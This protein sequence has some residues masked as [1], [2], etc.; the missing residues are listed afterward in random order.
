M[1]LTAKPYIC[2]FCRNY[3]EMQVICR[4]QYSRV[5]TQGTEGLDECSTHR[6][7]ILACPLCDNINVWEIS[8][9]TIEEEMIGEEPDG[10]PIFYA[11]DRLQLVYPQVDVSI[12]SPNADM[13]QEVRDDYD[14]AFRVF[15]VSP[16]GASALLRL[17]I[18]K[19]CKELGEPGHNINNDISA[20]VR[21]GLPN[22][23]Q[24]ALD[25][26]RVIGNESVHPGELDI[27]DNPE[28]AKQLFGLINEIVDDRI[29][30]PKKINSIQT[31]YDGLPSS[32]RDA[33]R[34]RDQSG[35]SS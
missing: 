32:K 19:L 34:R 7:E 22:H 4:G 5:Y 29:S 26:V 31:V 28:I 17:A 24:Q 14:E 20:L 18:Q 30:K 23:I 33:I 8:N 27:D 6:W 11:P 1:E 13:P 16:R 3:A 15:K 12:P 9:W 10:T 25:I 2:G 35:S 21:R